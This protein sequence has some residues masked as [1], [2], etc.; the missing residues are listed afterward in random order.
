MIHYEQNPNLQEV[1]WN[2]LVNLFTLVGWGKREP[3]EYENAS[4]KSSVI[5]LVKKNGAIIGV[6]RT[7][8]DGKYYAMLVDVVVHPD[9][10]SGGIG[11]RIVE[12]LK[13]ML[14]GY[15]FITLSA[16]PGK[17]GFYKK[18]GWRKQ[19]SAFIMP[20]NQRQIDE[21]CE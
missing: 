4:S 1:D 17:D 20:I 15:L 8:D 5:I 19:K 11:R 10:Q 7:I 2:Q 6:G 13:N 3:A 9:Y 18:I 14:N 12:E 16:A 21:H